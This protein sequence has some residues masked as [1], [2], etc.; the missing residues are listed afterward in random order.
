MKARI[1]QLKTSKGRG[2]HAALIGR[3]VG[4][5]AIS[6]VL[7]VLMMLYLMPTLAF[8]NP[9]SNDSGSGSGSGSPPDVVAASQNDGDDAASNG[10]DAAASGSSNSNASSA[11]QPSTTAGNSAAKA[12]EQ[13]KTKTGSTTAKATS[14][15]TASTAKAGGNTSKQQ[16]SSQSSTAAKAAASTATTA[17]TDAATSGKSTAK[18]KAVS[19]KNAA[20]TGST[21]ATDTDS[22]KPSAADKVAADKAAA[23]KA[24]AAKAAAAKAAADKAKPQTHTV[25][26]TATAKDG[27][28]LTGF[29]KTFVAKDGQSITLSGQAATPTSVGRDFVGWFYKTASGVE[30]RFYFKGAPGVSVAQATKVSAD[31]AV[32][33]KFTDKTY[34]VTFYAGPAT[35]K[36]ASAKAAAKVLATQ[37]LAWGQTVKAFPELPVS[38]VPK[39]YSF[40]GTWLNRANGQVFD[41]SKPV[42]AKLALEPKLE[43]SFIANAKGDDA[44]AEDKTGLDGLDGLGAGEP[45]MTPPPVPIVPPAPIVPP[46]PDESATPENNSNVTDNGNTNNG[47]TTDP[48]TTGEATG[49]G[50]EDSANAASTEEQQQLGATPEAAG[51]TG[52]ADPAAAAG[53]AGSADPAASPESNALAEEGIATDLEQV[54]TGFLEPPITKQRATISLSSLESASGLDEL[55]GIEPL[56]DALPI[57]MTFYDTDNT[58]L[59]HVTVGPDGSFEDTSFAPPTNVSAPSDTTQEWSGRWV[60]ANGNAFSLTQPITSLATSVSLYPELRE[61]S[62]AST[63]EPYTMKYYVGDSADPL[64]F[65]QADS[66]GKVMDLPLLKVNWP[67]GA[68]G[69]LGWYTQPEGGTKFDFN[70]ALEGDA[71]VYARFS[72]S[73]MI[74]YKNGPGG[75]VFDSVV[76]EAGQPISE[77]AG[78][79]FDPPAGAG[80]ENG[81]VDY[82]YDESDTAMT[83]FNFIDSTAT[84]D[85]TLVAHWSDSYWVYF[86]SNGG[87]Q[88]DSLLVKGGEQFEAPTDPQRVGFQFV[89]W[90]IKG[91]EDGASDV[92]FTFD[93]AGL[94]TATITAD[95]TLTAKWM[96]DQVDY[97][98]VVWL[99]KPNFGNSVDDSPDPSS[100]ADYNYVN[101]VV[102]KGTAGEFTNY[103]DLS[104]LPQ[105]VRDLFAAGDLR[106][107]D[108]Q[109]V[110]NAKILGNESTVI[111]V[112]ATRKIYI[113][114]F[115]LPA[116]NSM[117]FKGTQYSNAV[118]Y[119]LRVKYEWNVANDWPTPPSASF[120]LANGY[121]YSMW[122]STTEMNQIVENT[123]LASKRTV[124]DSALLPAN[125]SNTGPLTFTLQTTNTGTPVEFRYFVEVVGNMG[126]NGEPVLAGAPTITSNGKIYVEMDVYRQTMSDGL[127]AKTI[128]GLR[129]LNSNNPYYYALNSSG[130]YDPRGDYTGGYNGATYSMTGYPPLYQPRMPAADLI[131]AF[132]YDRQLA[133]VHFVPNLPDGVSATTQPSS[134]PTD[135]TL[136][137]QQAIGGEPAAEPELAGYK[138][139]G[140]YTDAGGNQEF[141]FDATMT[142]VDG[143]NSDGSKKYATVAYAKWIPIANTVTYCDALNA[144]S[145]T[146][147]GDPQPITKGSPVDLTKAPLQ[148]GEAVEGKGVFDAWYVYDSV[149]R[150][151][152][153]WNKDQ[154][155]AGDLKLY[156]GYKTG[157]F[158]LIYDAGTGSGDTPLDS[159]TYRLNESARLSYGDDIEPPTGTVLVGWTAEYDGA[160][161]GEREK[162][163]ALGSYYPMKADTVMTAAYGSSIT[164]T[165]HSNYLDD[166][167]ANEV[168]R[169]VGAQEAEGAYAFITRDG[170]VVGLTSNKSFADNMATTAVIVGWN[171]KEDGSGKAYGLNEPVGID[172]DDEN[173]S[174]GTLHLYAIWQPAVYS[175]VFVAGSN[176]KLSDAVKTKVSSINYTR[177]EGGTDWGIAVAN[178]VPTP[179]PNEGYKFVAWHEKN[180]SGAVVQSMPAGDIQVFKNYS[181]YAEFA[182]A[183]YMVTFDANGG[184]AAVPGSKTVTFNSPYG[185][186]ATTSRQD[187]NFAGWFTAAEGGTKVTDA[188]VVATPNSHTLYAQWKPVI[189]VKVP[190]T[191]VYG[192]SDFSLEYVKAAIQEKIG[193]KLAELELE[194]SIVIN[195]T[196]RAKDDDNRTGESVKS[197]PY[198]YYWEIVSNTS[199]IADE[200][201]SIDAGLSITPRPLTISISDATK[202]Y[203]DPPNPDPKFKIVKSDYK[204]EEGTPGSVGYSSGSGVLPADEAF[205]EE[206]MNTANLEMGRDEGEDPGS[207]EVKW[208]E[209]RQFSPNY[210]ITWENG[211]LK[212]TVAVTYAPGVDDNSVTN[213]PNSLT[214]DYL[215]DDTVTAAGD[216]SRTGYTFIGWKSSADGLTYG[217]AE[218]NPTSFAMPAVNVTLTAQWEID[219]SQTYTIT[220][221]TDGNG[222]A[223]PGSE[224]HQVLFSG[225]NTGSTAEANAGYKFRD[226]TDKDGNVVATTATYVPVPHETATY[227]ANFEPT[228]LQVTFDAN[229]GEAATPGSKTVTF[230]SSYGSL[231]STSRPG[232]TFA[233]WFTSPTGGTQVTPSTVVSTPT[234]H[235]LYAHWA[236]VDYRVTYNTAG[237]SPATITDSKNPYH[238]TDA[239]TVLS[240]VPTRTGYT[241]TGWKSDFGSNA[242]YQ[243]GSGFTMPAANVT[244]TAQWTPVVSPPTPTYTVTFTDGQGNT[245]KVQPNIPSGGSAT[246]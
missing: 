88:V 178:G 150:T 85:L 16:A 207:Y 234:D 157:G 21:T 193:D 165:Y 129:P 140:W 79:D 217:G 241:F 43:L 186:L 60:D 68:T 117:T 1:R 135:R 10:D 172:I 131:R 24:A 238:V 152:G 162:V 9:S 31:L 245:L 148:E 225:A 50:Q 218:G 208:G 53:A 205:F 177:A 28:S 154:V 61:K 194:G 72:T 70:Q 192:D 40:T 54:A 166:T 17:G 109:S 58:I 144:T 197:F 161:E 63:D 86:D 167:V 98:I 160:G 34:K 226:W 213:M 138:F 179:V 168:S 112:F 12:A 22:K 27:S 146:Q 190:F 78:A 115:R 104:S 99:E 211:L 158:K 139:D 67:A 8:G 11:T 18:G 127:Y 173:I 232:Y 29:P 65:M 155:V 141:N 223:D 59:A 75:D 38:A 209:G 228:T 176:G 180:A 220:Y 126:I 23:T 185:T 237:G 91:G 198:E 123:Q 230:D 227:T 114:E 44:T 196:D 175:I 224:T 116:G 74:T 90:V 14:A 122:G 163:W 7:T 52:P 113:Y 69:F 142:A 2:S 87:S 93:A 130:G 41:L 235:T 244:L 195:V 25:K 80:V 37:T 149:S 30:K 95:T 94:S 164:I 201:I 124:I 42:T 101:S 184:E 45:L 181:Y 169:S 103:G 64:Q 200:D 102:L 83:P 182:P 236:P 133:T 76:L 212:I 3:D 89:G 20:A 49:P 82:W 92:D 97:T 145:A 51:A 216:P 199:T 4:R 125:G 118:P 170:S 66:N 6:I 153:K 243:P 233:G 71:S 33:A 214:E 128:N 13:A 106:Y 221:T 119:T 5:R 26:V 48:A 111:N 219:G 231:A 156:A 57:E 134:W 188:T 105:S 242:I 239:V 206:E 47:S 137:Y 204:S 100:P 110:V 32:Y 132:L 108:F 191:K 171:T 35:G 215:P 151:F 189:D 183:S 55:L 246:A 143:T 19:D 84:K 15:A 46:V 120:A 39:G 174:N 222:T 81:H 62:T 202:Q 77:Y 73:F 240:T 56:A 203:D 107:A 147:L 36:A 210:A 187:Y 229:G 159:K 136:S 96:G 121:R